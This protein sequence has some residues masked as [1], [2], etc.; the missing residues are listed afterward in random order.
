MCVYV[1]VSVCV[2]VCVSVC[3]R[4]CHG[5]SRSFAQPEPLGKGSQ[6]I[7]AGCSKAQSRGKEIALNI[8]IK[9]KSF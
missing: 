8:L 1:C 3:A 9:M 5:G 6:T 7:L 2:I 4:V